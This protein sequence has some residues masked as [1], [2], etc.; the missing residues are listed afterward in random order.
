MARK[1]SAGESAKSFTSVAVILLLVVTLCGRWTTRCLKIQSSNREQTKNAKLRAEIKEDQL[2][3]ST[4]LHQ[5]AGAQARDG[6]DLTP[7]PI[8]PGR[9][10]PFPFLRQSRN[11]DNEDDT[12]RIKKL[13]R[14]NRLKR[15]ETQKIRNDD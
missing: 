4:A 8:D 11:L 12:S 9:A 2:L 6:G 10:M 3:V 14:K 15:T 13:N 5:R 7:V 1:R